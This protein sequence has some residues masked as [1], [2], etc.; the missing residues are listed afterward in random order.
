MSALDIKKREKVT[1]ID[2][3]SAPQK[4]QRYLPHFLRQQNCW[5]IFSGK[6]KFELPNRVTY[7]REPKVKTG[8]N[9][10]IIGSPNWTDFIL[11]V[12]FKILTDSIRPPEGGTILY[13]HFK[14][15]K[16]YYSCHVCLFKKR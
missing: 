12:R 2:L 3:L 11:K 13:F 10:S 5:K 1:K 4:T 9:I 8:E 16:N 15:F 6:W 14:N 7:F